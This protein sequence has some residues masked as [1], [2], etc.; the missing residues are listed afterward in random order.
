[1]AGNDNSIDS[2]IVVAG[3]IGCFLVFFLMFFIPFID[4]LPFILGGVILLMVIV[5][6]GVS[7]SGFSDPGTTGQNTRDTSPQPAPV[8]EPE[9]SPALPGKS[10]GSSA[11]DYFFW[12]VIAVLFA[13]TVLFN[14]L[15]RM[16]FNAQTY[17]WC[18]LYFAGLVFFGSI[19]GFGIEFWKAR[20]ENQSVPDAKKALYLPLARKGLILFGLFIL[21]FFFFRI[22]KQ[23]I[24]GE[25]VPETDIF[26]LGILLMLL[27]LYYRGYRYLK[28]A[29]GESGKGSRLENLIGFIGEL[30][31]FFK[32]NFAGYILAAILL[33]AGIALVL[34]L[35]MNRIITLDLTKSAGFLLFILFAF[36]NLML[37][38]LILLRLEYIKKHPLSES[39]VVLPAPPGT[40]GF[41]LTPQAGTFMM[42][43]LMIGFLIAF[44]AV[45]FL[46]ADLVFN[47][48]PSQKSSIP[49]NKKI[50]IVIG[51]TDPSKVIVHYYEGEDSDRLVFLEAMIYDQN[52]TLL[53]RSV[54]GSER[55]ISPL[56]DSQI[57]FSGVFPERSR[58]IV[59]GHFTDGTNQIVHESLL[60]T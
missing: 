47:D 7:F 30:F 24:Q 31:R 14:Q 44:F 6:L 9:T 16:Y 26:I 46:A 15:T 13:G 37:F 27:Y 35:A 21:A 11:L 42:G 20:R 40:P 2:V 41:Y 10:G 38:A 18:F 49:E 58:I 53:D 45:P 50:N 29:V 60:S 4:L 52:S 12:S 1:M 3:I 51:N 33:N 59:R 17:L 36:G 32:G 39:G 8:Q 19:A 54:L 28:P 48:N 25:T 5:V 56:R 23:S 34:Y 55:E 43:I 57:V 22:W